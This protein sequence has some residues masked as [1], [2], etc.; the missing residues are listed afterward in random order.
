VLFRSAG[1]SKRIDDFIAA[2]GKEK[3]VE[4]ARSG[5]TAMEM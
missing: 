4:V 2:I 3:I 1:N 5:F